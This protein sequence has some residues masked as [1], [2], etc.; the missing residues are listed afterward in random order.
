MQS[1]FERGWDARYYEQIRSAFANA[2]VGW[3]DERWVIDCVLAELET[4]KGS[5]E[6][7]AMAMV[8]TALSRR[9]LG[10]HTVKFCVRMPL[11]LSTRHGAPSAAKLVPFAR[12]SL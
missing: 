11:R 6:R 3:K 12:Y 9:E 7:E 1:A 4:T 5:V 8:P 10:G 2:G